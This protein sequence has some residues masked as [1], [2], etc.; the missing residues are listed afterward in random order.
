MLFGAGNCRTVTITSP[1]VKDGKTT[2]AANLAISLA[3]SGKRV[4][5]IDANFRDPFIYSAFDMDN[6][7]GLTSVLDGD[8]LES[9][10]RRTP[11]EHLDVLTAGPKSDDAS[12]KL[13]SARFLELIRDLSLR[14]DHVIFDTPAIA[15]N[16]DARVIAAGCDQT[17]LVVRGERSNRFATTTARDALL[18]VGAQLMGI[19][20]NDWQRIS[21]AYPP[22]VERGA[23]GTAGTERA[24]RMA[25]ARE[26]R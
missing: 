23:P 9:S 20:M 17:I 16:N 15:G 14:Y 18:S 5:L 4:A 19:V 12:E 13:N 6:V 7:I 3:Q 24:Q 11:I 25:R 22:G 8:D 1:A 26:R 2:L 10:L 21:Q